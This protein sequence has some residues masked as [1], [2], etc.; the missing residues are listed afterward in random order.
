VAVDTDEPKLA[1]AAA[2]P[3]MLAEQALAALPQ[4]VVN[5]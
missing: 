1:L 3:V 4:K 2:P 5:A